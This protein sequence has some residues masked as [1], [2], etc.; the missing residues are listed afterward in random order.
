MVPN[1]LPEL[2]VCVCAC[3]YVCVGAHVYECACTLVAF[4]WVDCMPYIYY[5]LPE[6]ILC[7]ARVGFGLPWRNN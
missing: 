7:A 4:M 1:E 6:G 2:C 3:V 5:M